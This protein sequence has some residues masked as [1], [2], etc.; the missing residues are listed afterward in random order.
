MPFISAAGRRLEYE[1]IDGAE[2]T[3]VFLHEGLGS[4][5]QWRD[6]PQRVAAATGRRALIY[7]RYGYGDSDVLAEDRVG[8]DF[9]HIEALK[10]LPKVLSELKIKNPVL[11][12]HSDGASIAL[13]HAGSGYF[14][15]GLVLLAPHVFV[16]ESG[17]ESIRKVQIDFEKLGKYHRDPKKTFHLWSDAWLDPAFKRWNIEWLLKPIRCPIL[18]IQGEDDVYGSMAQLDAIKSRVSGPCELLKL[19]DCGHAPQRDQ[20]EKVLEAVVKFVSELK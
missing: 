15:R 12:G 2:P 14:V 4:I 9:M 18:A 11:I 7:S 5:R 10:F 8:T 1:T 17:L 16:E 3:L 20:P 6:F 19:P 13:I